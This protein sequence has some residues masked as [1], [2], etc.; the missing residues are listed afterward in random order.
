MSKIINGTRVILGSAFSFFV[1]VVSLL[2]HERGMVYC[3]GQYIGNQTVV[4][5][6]HCVRNFSR[7]ICVSFGLSQLL[8]GN[9]C[10][11]G[12]VGAH[13]VARVTLH[14]SWDPVTMD[15]DIAVLRLEKEPGGAVAI[16]VAD[17]SRYDGEGTRLF[18]LG[19][20]RTDSAEEQGILRMS[21]NVVVLP[22]QK[23]ERLRVNEKVMLVAGDP[24]VLEANATLAT[25]GYT[26]TCQGDS[27][28]PLFHFNQETNESVLV[29]I[30]S[31][32][33]GCGY[34]GL[35]GVYTRVSAMSDWIRDQM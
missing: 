5:A 31:W 8:H 22:P 9:A 20:G 25:H 23:F 3:G 17:S 7:E 27:G 32:G 10:G 14:P 28:G 6:A 24:R 4:T 15:N 2:S 1:S 19:F 21:N 30:T 29:G 16:G 26:D 11:E 35:P 33:I 18:I 34:H 13:R 12:F